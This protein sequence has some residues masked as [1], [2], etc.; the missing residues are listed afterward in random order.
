MLVAFIH[1]KIA[2]DGAECQQNEHIVYYTSINA[3]TASS[4]PSGKNVEKKGNKYDV[5][6][7]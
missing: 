5:G 7:G 6:N 4:V 3:P 2:S 1:I